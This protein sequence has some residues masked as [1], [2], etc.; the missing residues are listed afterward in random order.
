MGPHE[1]SR[2]SDLTAQ[3]EDAAQ[4]AFRVTGKCLA[5]NSSLDGL[6]NLDPERR[7]FEKANYEHHL[8]E[9][10]ASALAIRDEFYKGLAIRQIINVC[11]RAND[12]DIAKTL[13][14]EVGH[15]SLREQIVKDAPELAG[16]KKVLADDAPTFV[17]IHLD[18]VDHKAIVHMV[19]KAMREGGASECEIEGFKEDVNTADLATLLAKAIAWGA[20]VQ[21][22]KDGQPWISGDWR[23]L[24]LWQRLKRRFSLLRGSYVHPDGTIELASEDRS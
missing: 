24:T 4:A 3:H 9:A 10:I 6:T 11:R 14:K 8:V 20:P 2:M 21:F 18:G 13:F 23:R 7:Q 19:T 15:H 1:G 5:A 16:E 17:T 12:F 22:L